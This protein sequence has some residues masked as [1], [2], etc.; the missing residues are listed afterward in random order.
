LA[1]AEVEKLSKLSDGEFLYLTRND[2]SK[3]N[4]EPFEA[5]IEKQ[6]I[7]IPETQ[8][9]Q[10]V[11]R[12]DNTMISMAKLFMLGLWCLVVVTALKGML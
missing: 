11:Q 7:S 4:I 2:L 6:Q 9:I 5:M 8:P 1:R 10:H 12:N 3:I